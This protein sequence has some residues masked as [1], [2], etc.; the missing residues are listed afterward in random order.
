MKESGTTH[1]QQSVMISPGEAT[2]STPNAIVPH[3]PIAPD[4]TR[5]NEMNSTGLINTEHPPQLETAANAHRST[6]IRVPLSD[7]PNMLSIQLNYTIPDAPRFLPII[8]DG[9]MAMFRMARNMYKPINTF[10]EYK[11][12]GLYYTKS[13]NYADYHERS[14][15][16]AP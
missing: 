8:I 15:D 2:S 3:G 14:T 4:G 9:R 7:D 1:D 6:F 16:F 12:G 5:E 11:A 10:L 13:M